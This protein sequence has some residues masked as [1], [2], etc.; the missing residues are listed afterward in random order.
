ML[1]V[2]TLIGCDGVR[3]ALLIIWCVNILEKRE[4][5]G[6][7]EV[8]CSLVDLLASVSPLFKKNITAL[9]KRKSDR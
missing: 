2:V 8:I 9:I 4:L 1:V 6:I 3:A 5:F 7:Y